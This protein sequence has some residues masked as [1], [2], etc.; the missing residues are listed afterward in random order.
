MS[1]SIV[2][3]KYP[4]GTSPGMPTHNETVSARHS[5]NPKYAGLG[6]RCECCEI[7]ADYRLKCHYEQMRPHYRRYTW[8]C[9]NCHWHQ[10]E[11]CVEHYWHVKQIALLLVDDIVILIQRTIYKTYQ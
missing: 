3:L 4:C 6:Y 7:S 10:L 8:M 11:T 1:K 9:K 5:S 2:K